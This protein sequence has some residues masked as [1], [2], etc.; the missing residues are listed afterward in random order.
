[1]GLGAVSCAQQ[2]CG[3]ICVFDA[4]SAN[5]CNPGI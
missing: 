3:D 4:D 1:M 2:Q 5:G